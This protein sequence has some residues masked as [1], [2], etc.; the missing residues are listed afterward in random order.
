MWAACSLVQNAI[1]IAA[2]FCLM[3]ILAVSEIWDTA[4][5]SHQCKNQ[6]LHS[7]PCLIPMKEL[8]AFT[9]QRAHSQ[10]NPINPALVALLQAGCLPEGQATS[11]EH[12]CYQGDPLCALSLFFPLGLGVLLGFG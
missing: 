2:S 12:Q 10:G 1:L 3:V 9:G 11:E 8:W 4:R 5:E 7:S 6:T